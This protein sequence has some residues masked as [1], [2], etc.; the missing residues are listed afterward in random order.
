M[1]KTIFFKDKKQEQEFFEFIEKIVDEEINSKY[2]FYDNKKKR[3]VK[4]ETNQKYNEN[5]Q[6]LYEIYKINQVLSELYKF[7]GINN[8]KNFK[9][10][11]TIF[12]YIV[13]KKLEQKDE[14]F[15]NPSFVNQEFEFKTIYKV[16]IFF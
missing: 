4:L 13:Q 3:Y 16:E 15:I 9:N 7:D 2:N 10:L 11:K 8:I 6:V 14:R 12:R 1:K 5:K